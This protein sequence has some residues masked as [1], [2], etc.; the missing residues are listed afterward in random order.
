MNTW[1]RPGLI[2]AL[3]LLAGAAQYF[4]YAAY[5]SPRE[6]AAHNLQVLTDVLQLEARKKTTRHPAD[7]RGVTI[8]DL[9]SRVQEFAAQNAVTLVAIEPLAG[10][11]E[12]FKLGL[13]SD[14]GSFLEFLARFE[15]LQVDVN[16]LDV[17][18]AMDTPGM[19][20]I[21]LSF[22]HTAA[23]SA[24]PQERIKAF[25]ARLKATAL[26]DPFNPAN[27]AAQMVSDISADDRFSSF[28]LTSISEIGN[29]RYATIDGKDYSVGDQLEGFV[30]SQ[31]ANDNVTLIG[32]EDGK[33]HR[34]FLT[35]R[36]SHKERT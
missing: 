3:V 4:I 11:A 16:G 21:S 30:V 32:K 13:V 33:E 2:G 24:I 7:A 28:H 20:H 10:D 29:T 1:Y 23:P 12:Q 22:S 8:P 27:G 14:Y 25:M 6:T 9:L 5:V 18:P 26:R 36:N 19:L 17:A 31:I 34:R 15:T 35:F